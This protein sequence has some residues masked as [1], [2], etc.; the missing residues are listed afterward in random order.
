VTPPRKP[1]D[2][3]TGPRRLN[4]DAMDI[5]STAKFLG[6]TPKLVRARYARRQLPGRKWGGRVVFLRS[7]LLEFLRGL[8][9]VPVAEALANAKNGTPA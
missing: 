7:E 6:A 8:D 9:G 4:G 1:A 3:K 2:K 5:D